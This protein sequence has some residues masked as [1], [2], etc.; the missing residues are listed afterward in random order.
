MAY[1]ITWNVNKDGD[2]SEFPKWSTGHTPASSDT[3]LIDTADHHTIM[4]TAGTATVK[5]LTVGNDDF[6]MSGG[7][8]T[9]KTAASFANVLTVGNGK[10]TLSGASSVS[11]LFTANNKATILGTGALTL[12]GGATFT[13]GTQTMKG[14]AHT[15]L[16]G[17]SALAANDILNLGAGRVLENQGT[18]TLNDHA[19]I[20]LGK[21]GDNATLQNNASA[22]LIFDN[23]TLTNA[24]V[25]GSGTIAF[26]NAGTIQN[27]G[28]GETQIG[29]TFTNTGT[30]S[31]MAGQID[32]N[33][34]M[35]GSGTVGVSSGATFVLNA[36]TIAAANA[37]NFSDK[38]GTVHLNGGSGADTFA[39]AGGFAATDTVAGNAGNDTLSLTGNYSDGVTLTATTI[40]KVETL[41][42]GAGFDYLITTNNANVASTTTLKVDASALGA[43]DT[44]TFNGAAETDG[45][46]TITGGAGAD[47]LTGGAKGDTFNLG[48][49]GVDT[50]TGNGGDDTVVVTSALP[51]AARIDGGIGNDTVKFS[52]DFAAGL[53]L[54]N[55]IVNVEKVTFAKGFNYAL[56]TDD[57]LVAAGKTITINAG[58]VAKTNWLRFDGSAETDGHFAITGSAGD[59]VLKGGALSDDIQAGNGD[60]ASTANG[61]DTVFGGGGD[62]TIRFDTFGT[63]DK[64][65]GGDGNDTLHLA[66][67]YWG[68]NKIVL[69]AAMMTNVET[70]YL[71]YSHAGDG[72]IGYDITTVDANVAAGQT[73]T[74]DASDI[75]ND[76]V[77]QVIFNGSAETD[78]TFVILGG[79][80]SDILSGGAGNDTINGGA[81]DDI[82]NGRGG[83][84]TMSGGTGTNTI[85][86]DNAED[87]IIHTTGAVD[88]VK[89]T[90]S[91]SAD[92]VGIAQMWFVG[93]GDFTFTGVKGGAVR[94]FGATGNDT[95]DSG[96]SDPVVKMQLNGGAGNDTYIVRNSDVVVAEGV[97]AGTDQV[98]T[99][100][101]KY[102]LTGNVEN[103]STF[104]T[105]AFTGT[106]NAIAN[107]IVG[108]AK[109]DILKG[110]GGAD[111]LTGGDGADHFVY[112][113]ANESS[114]ATYDTIT[115][116]D[117]SKDKIDTTIAVAAVDSAINT[118]AL[119]IGSF[120]ANLALVL[121]AAHLAKHHAVVFTADSGTL[122]GDHFLVVDINGTAGYQSGG[123]LVIQLEGSFGTVVKG[124][125]I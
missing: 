52:G 31:V 125:F 67:D 114:G 112:G 36:T 105:A 4:F 68:V 99:T 53:I 77:Q 41:K 43:N 121:D 86:I 14:A 87:T 119:S 22:T 23:D 5:S 89:T 102:T 38:A 15:I 27:T 100:L 21:A 94:V 58:A 51:G 64:V 2:W 70:L 55:T 29:A 49:G 81:G 101:A 10:L 69:T 88:I 78:G 8:L 39:F 47:V 37:V 61:A 46:F 42:F 20:G 98:Q 6:V 117:A 82:L 83:A 35:T 85:F 72:L 113:A 71:A 123:D 45:T 60:P 107:A 116:F 1:S 66:G 56:T 16:Q 108:G 93:T 96:T 57:A 90:L 111:T 33:A 17:T 73:L 103:L 106:G 110:A 118:G 76:D 122:A 50:V 24:V 92:I 65:D 91:N 7:A 115:D 30:V 18:L 11:G 13:G 80:N 109:G 19:S 97:N 26:T 75:S 79:E 74:V 44:L 34:R 62:D 124:D 63:T 12:A 25:K 84:D 104:G 120:D 95:L 28:A 32:V 59:D 3:V 48:A 54:S 9:I 40:T